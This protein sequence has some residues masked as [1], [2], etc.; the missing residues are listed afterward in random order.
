MLTRSGK[1]TIMPPKEK[2]QTV[3][4]NTLTTTLD[5]IL[6]KQ[7]APLKDDIANINSNMTQFQNELKDVKKSTEFAQASA[8]AAVKSAE[9]ANNRIGKLEATQERIQEIMDGG[10]E[11]V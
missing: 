4:M 11:I 8:D 3:D 2:P 6:Q 7:L 10:V 9:L 1:S 5:G